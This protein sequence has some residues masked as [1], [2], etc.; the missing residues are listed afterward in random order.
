MLR[1]KRQAWMDNED[2]MTFKGA[3]KWYVCAGSYA[4]C[5]IEEKDV[6]YMAR[7]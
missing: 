3:M 7:K 2:T 1:K 4:Y 5:F 6:I